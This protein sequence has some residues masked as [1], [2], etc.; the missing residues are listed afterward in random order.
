MFACRWHARCARAS[1]GQIPFSSFFLR[2][3]A[4]VSTSSSCYDTSEQLYCLSFLH[5]HPRS[6]SLPCPHSLHDPRTSPRRLHTVQSA[7][8]LGLRLLASKARLSSSPRSSS[9]S[10]SS[11]ASP[12]S[13]PA[14]RS[15]TPRGLRAINPA[16]A[17]MRS[18]HAMNR[19]GRWAKHGCP[20]S[21]GEGIAST[22][23]PTSF[24][25][26]LRDDAIDP[27]ALS[28]AVELVE[29]QLPN[30]RARDLSLFLLNAG[31]WNFPG[32][33]S[34][35]FRGVMRVVI[36]PT[37]PK[38]DA[39]LA[40]LAPWNTVFFLPLPRVAPVWS[41]N[42]FLCCSHLCSPCF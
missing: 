7:P 33:Q 16:P 15:A 6:S 9:P 40:H 24:A 19:L 35:C 17:V 8:P 30:L 32:L 10:R 4:S 14:S 18:L 36:P 5:R 25:H 41:L 13:Q 22:Y 34:T 42:I 26:L 28:A 27:A 37:I 20:S 23:D 39:S 3:I 31:R 12:R 2:W 11:P 21:P 38:A 29:Q 1:S